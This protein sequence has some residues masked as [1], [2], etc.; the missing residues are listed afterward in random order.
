MP[1]KIT[2]PD[3]DFFFTPEDLAYPRGTNGLASF[4]AMFQ[5][6]LYKENMYPGPDVGIPVPL[7]TWYERG[8]FG[9]V[10][11]TQNTIIPDTTNL[12]QVTEAEG[13]IFTFDFV[14]D[15]F[16]RWVNH[17]GD[18]YL[19]GAVSKQGRKAILAPRAVGGYSDPT[20]QF[21]QFHEGL[22]KAFITSFR[23]PREKPIENFKGFLEYYVPFLINLAPS[24]P[25]TKTNFVLSYKMDPMCNGLS[26][27]LYDGDAGDDTT[28]FGEF[29]QDPNFAFYTNSIKK[30]GFLVNK[31]KP[32][33][34]TADLFTPALQDR[35]EYYIDEVTHKPV[36]PSNFFNVYYRK[37]YLTDFDDLTQILLSAYRYLQSGAPLCQKETICPNG[38]FNYKSYPRELYDRDQLASQISPQLLIDTYLALRQAESSNTLTRIGVDRLRRRAYQ[39]YKLRHPGVALTPLQRVA[40][41]INLEYKKYI[42]P[43][44]LSRLTGIPLS[45]M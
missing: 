12:V 13:P 3:G 20:Q 5:R 27:S 23:P 6:T 45:M 40:H 25:M 35:L 16:T 33:I 1:V 10:D 9:R 32:W 30:Y 22:A 2:N 34:I 43:A 15:C 29:I 17:M 8:F 39:I 31:N 14:A 36:R 24:F 28:K 18:A 21:F 38:T 44:S 4:A 41:E 42:Y 7:D 11:R 19:M 26:L 37:T